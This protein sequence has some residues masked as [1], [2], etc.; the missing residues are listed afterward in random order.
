MDGVWQSAHPAELNRA[1]PLSI[2]A[3]LTLPTTGLVLVYA[4]TG[5]GGARNRMKLA[6]L[7]A[8]LD[9]RCGCVSSKFRRSSGYWLGVHVGVSSRSCGNK[10][11]ETPCS[12]LYASPAKIISDLFCAFHPKRVTVPAFPSRFSCPLTPITG[13][14]LM[15]S[16]IL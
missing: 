10:S 2:D 6:K 8:S 4:M 5:V 16:S 9:I 1:L 11:F 7:T 3:E 14:V 12:T 15:F 13:G